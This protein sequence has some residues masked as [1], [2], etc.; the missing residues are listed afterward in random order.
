MAPPRRARTAFL[1][2][3]LALAGCASMQIR[4]DYDRGVDFAHY[5]SFAWLEGPLQ[6][7]GET[8]AEPR[9]DRVDPFEWNSLLDKRVRSAVDQ[10]LLSRGFQRATGGDPD[11]WIRYH[12][13]LRDRTQVTSFPG[14][15]WPYG[16]PTAWG[17]GDL[18]VDSFQEGTL[19]LDVIDP[20]LN[21]LVWRGWAVRAVS[22]LA[23]Q[24]DEVQLAVKRIL[25]RF[26]PPPRS[27]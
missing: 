24:H 2:I 7:V 26:P 23:R 27:D 21:Q 8:P 16:G 12:T 18:Y 15:V 9:P 6:P 14:T 3:P 25:E 4:T 13:L 20:A 1:A 17:W 22:D 10:V 5:A 11:F 19:I